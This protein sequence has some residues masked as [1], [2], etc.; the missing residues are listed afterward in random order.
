[1][2]TRRKWLTDEIWSR[3]DHI[4]WFGRGEEKGKCTTV[5]WLI[6]STECKA[7]TIIRTGK[8]TGEKG[9]GHDPFGNYSLIGPQEM[10]LGHIFYTE[11]LFIYC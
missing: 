5:T 6:D 7:Q 9:T 4:S 1:M 2:W 11:E 8:E 3:S 10:K